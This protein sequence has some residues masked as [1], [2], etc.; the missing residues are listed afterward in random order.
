MLGRCPEHHGQQG[1]S[2][3]SGDQQYLPIH[4]RV[5]NAVD[6]RYAASYQPQSQHASRHSTGHGKK[7]QRQPQQLFLP[8]KGQQGQENSRR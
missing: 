5:K 3:R 4:I 7:Q 8:A 2:R 1:I 6:H